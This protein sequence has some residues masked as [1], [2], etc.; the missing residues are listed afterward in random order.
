MD[1][2]PSAPRPNGPS[3][4]D[5]P[6]LPSLRADL[7]TVTSLLFVLDRGHYADKISN[8]L[9]VAALYRAISL[10]RRGEPTLQVFGEV[11]LTNWARGFGSADFFNHLLPGNTTL[12]VT[13]I[14]MYR[15]EFAQLTG[16]YQMN[17]SVLLGKPH[18]VPDSVPHGKRED[19]LPPLF[20]LIR[21][22]ITFPGDNILQELL[23]YAE[24]PTKLDPSF[25]K[26][27]SQSLA[28][29][30]RRSGILSFTEALP[31]VDANA[32]LQELIVD[33]A[34]GSKHPTVFSTFGAEYKDAH[35]VAKSIWSDAREIAPGIFQLESPP[36]RE[37]D[38]LIRSCLRDLYQSD[39]EAQYV[40]ERADDG[41]ANALTPEES[42]SF[43]QRLRL[44]ESPTE[45]LEEVKR[46][47]AD[48][49]DTGAGVQIALGEDR[50]RDPQSIIKPILR[51]ARYIPDPDGCLTVLKYPES[52]DIE[53]LLDQI[54]VPMI[55]HR[56][57]W[58]ND[59]QTGR[60]KRMT[61]SFQAQHLPAVLRA[62]A[63]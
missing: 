47:L 7:R 12:L 9:T 41:A 30:Q 50:G 59:L 21:P 4:G 1:L 39:P 58:L 44:G 23:A 49:G 45:V 26:N 42:A 10:E 43:S 3:E 11:Q 36:S 56:T 19:L 17:D 37:R 51:D 62:L 25:R 55:N 13:S 35:L 27:L 16:T 15:R 53:K 54:G 5:N 60:A 33:L 20:P 40:F 8:L 63:D 18:L 34:S 38:S 29:L 31:S 32:V 57:F 61:I 46:L 24:C 14:S 22:L 52:S 6:S 2:T 28:T 48:R